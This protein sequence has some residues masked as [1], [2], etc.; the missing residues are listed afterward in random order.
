MGV[1]PNH[2]HLLLR[3]GNAPIFKVMSRLLSGYADSFNRRHRRSGHLFHNRYKSILCQED[4]YLLVL[5]RYIHLNPLLLFPNWQQRWMH[6]TLYRFSGHSTLMGY[7]DNA[8]Q[9]VRTTALPL[10]GI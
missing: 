7:Q 2:F 5:V 6:W 1:M 8:W 10:F 3:T 9:D 4:T